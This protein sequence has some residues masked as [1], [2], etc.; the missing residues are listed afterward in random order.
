[1]ALAAICVANG[2]FFGMG[3][4]ANAQFY[5]HF[6][7]SEVHLIG[8]DVNNTFSDCKNYTAKVLVQ[9]QAFENH[10]FH[11]ERDVAANYCGDS[12]STALAAAKRDF[13][14][15]FRQ[16][17]WYDIRKPNVWTWDI[18]NAKWIQSLQIGTLAAAP[19]AMIFTLFTLANVERFRGAAQ[20]AAS[21]QQASVNAEREPLIE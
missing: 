20:L 2:V 21:S 3:W 13:P 4:Q 6:N 16:A 11:T 10:T 17:M 1:V 5:K 7:N 15:G 19:V 9:Y 14:P 12:S 8:Y 18:P